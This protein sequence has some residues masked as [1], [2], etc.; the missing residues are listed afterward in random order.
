MPSSSVTVPFDFHEENL[1]FNK[2]RV[3]YDLYTRFSFQKKKEKH[4][5]RFW[6]KS[7][8]L[9]LSNLATT[10]NFSGYF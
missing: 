7:I 10:Y 5:L 1:H 3:V 4:A 6:K 9:N 2:N 8:V